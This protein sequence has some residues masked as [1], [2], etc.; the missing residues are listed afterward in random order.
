MSAHVVPSIVSVIVL[1]PP[2]SLLGPAH[3]H[4]HT[5]RHT[6]KKE[7]AAESEGRTVS[8]ERSLA[9]VSE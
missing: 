3:T 1:P 6:Q 8:L 4:T 7:E 2:F 5:H 9:A